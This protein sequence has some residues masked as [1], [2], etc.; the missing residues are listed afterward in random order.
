MI[1]ER[2]AAMDFEIVHHQ[3][4]LAGKGIAGDQALDHA[5]ELSRRAVGRGAG[6]VPPGLGLHDSEDVGGSAALVFVVALGN[7]TRPRRPARTDI[8][9]QTNQLFIETDH[10]FGA[11]VRLLV[12]CQNIFHPGDVFL[13]QLGHARHFFP[14]RLQVVALE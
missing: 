5:G 10:W 14:P 11:A 12:Q 4:N 7:V 1:G 13:I 6:K 8:V 2:L 9:A 3:I